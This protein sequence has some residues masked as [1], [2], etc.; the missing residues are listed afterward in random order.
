[1][2]RELLHK[3]SRGD[4]PALK[5]LLERHL[6]GLHAYIRL[7]AGDLIR[8]KES[9]SDLVQSVCCEVL[10]EADNFDY[11]GE[12][13]FRRWLYTAALHKVIDK[14]RYYRAGKRDAKREVSREQISEGSAQDSRLLHAYGDFCTPSREAIVQEE[15]T[16]IEV[17]FQELP[18][19]YREVITMSR[20]WRFT[21]SQIAD[22]LNKTEDSVRMLLGRALAR[23][24]SLLE[25][26]KPPSSGEVPP[27]S[28]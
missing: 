4:P 11:Q 3:A 7:Q 26:T 6:D 21:N 24:S 23:F 15:L 25:R 8:R 12:P 27:A 18:E 5:T 28:S 1:V 9:V 16:R 22:E 17:A 10:Q 19:H 20:I 13:Q 2:D 14:N